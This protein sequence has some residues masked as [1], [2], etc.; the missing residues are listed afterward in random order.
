[1]WGGKNNFP[2][3]NSFAPVFRKRRISPPK[4]E[5]KGGVPPGGGPLIEM[6][7]PLGLGLGGPPGGPVF[8]F[9][10]FLE[11]NPVKNLTHP[12]PGFGFPFSSFSL[13][14]KAPQQLTFFAQRQRHPLVAEAWVV[15]HVL[16]NLIEAL[17][18]LLSIVF[19]LLFTLSPGPRRSLGPSRLFSPICTVHVLLEAL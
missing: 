1:M 12:S 3:G 4:R 19:D 5:K 9:F 16:T 10:F 13:G 8:F 18:R 7:D 6:G 15:L 17:H 11:T 2:P 14:G